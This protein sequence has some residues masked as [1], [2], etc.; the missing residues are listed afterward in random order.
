MPDKGGTAHN[1]KMTKGDR[2]RHIS[3]TQEFGTRYDL[4]AIYAY[5]E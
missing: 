3:E 5:P 2:V 4:H 1:E